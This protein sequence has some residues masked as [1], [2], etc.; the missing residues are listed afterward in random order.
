MITQ[1]DLIFEGW[2]LNAF[3]TAGCFSAAIYKERQQKSLISFFRR[4]E[5]LLIY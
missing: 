3:R 4:V 2:L 1:M 5:Q